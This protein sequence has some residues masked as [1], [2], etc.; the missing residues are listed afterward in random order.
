MKAEGSTTG[1]GGMGA[2]S[3][4]AVG[5]SVFAPPASQPQTGAAAQVGAGA[6]AG[7]AQPQV[8]A[9]A[10]QAGA[11]QLLQAGLQHL[12]WQQEKMRSSRQLFL[13]H[14]PQLD[15]QP[16]SQPQLGAGAAQSQADLLQLL[17]LLQ[18]ERQ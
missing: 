8:G 2:T 5:A 15:L 18:D 10:A 1:A 17:Q 7:A 12:L 4:P 13:Q 11:E 9:A 6:G 14:E 16:L 3:P